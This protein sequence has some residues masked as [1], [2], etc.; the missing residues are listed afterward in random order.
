MLSYAS[1]LV[2]A[3]IAGVLFFALTKRFLATGSLVVGNFLVHIIN[4][5]SGRVL[6]CDNGLE[7][8]PDAPTES[9]LGARTVIQHELGLHGELLA[10]AD[11]M[12]FLQLL[13]SMF[14]HADFL[15]LL[16]NVIVLLAFA[17][18]FE[19]RIGH[20]PFLAIYLGTGVFAALAEL[21][22]SWGEPILLIGASGAVF[23]IIG[24]FAAAYPS[25]V[26]P[27]PLPLLYIMIFVRMRVIV[28]AGLMAAQQILLQWLSQ[29]QPSNTAYLAHIGGLVAGII[30]GTTYVRHRRR[31]ASRPA[32][33]AVLDLQKLR[34]FATTLSAQN[35]LARLGTVLDDPQLAQIWGEKFLEHA[36]CPESGGPIRIENGFVVCP[37]GK[38]IDVRTTPSMR[39]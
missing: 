20:R 25:L 29:Y 32:P 2:L 3:I 17:L 18:P 4:V 23:G 12:G 22:P 15:H 39:P 37:D 26:L 10:A 34:P 30:L 27:L 6:V 28:A 33:Q 36:S 38:R 7:C 5:F 9:I 21:A 13:T 24:A 35:A 19:E 14:V 8:A 16:G 31:E 1:I 11:P